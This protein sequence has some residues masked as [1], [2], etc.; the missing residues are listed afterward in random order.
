MMDGL[1]CSGVWGFVVGWSM[2]LDGGGRNTGVGCCDGLLA[3]G[4][5]GLSCRGVMVM[6]MA[7]E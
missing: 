3:V 5:V 2:L 6:V 1:G 7:D 4:I